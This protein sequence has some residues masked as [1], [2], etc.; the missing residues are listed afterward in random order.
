MCELG[1]LT[2]VCPTEYFQIHLIWGGL[3]HV[4]P[5]ECFGHIL[6]FQL[7]PFEH[8]LHISENFL[9]HLTKIGNVTA[10]P[11]G[12]IQIFSS[13]LKLLNTVFQNFPQNLWCL[14]KHH[15]L[16]KLHSN[17]TNKYSHPNMF[18]PN[19]TPVS[20][21][22]YPSILAVSVKRECCPLRNLFMLKHYKLMAPFANAS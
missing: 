2:R 7:S 14:T 22:N 17:T 18:S 10:K 5:E 19:L 3:T 15:F 13:P 8:H 20:V 6:L 12:N 4:Q 9:R 1:N 16:P 11:L 21:Q